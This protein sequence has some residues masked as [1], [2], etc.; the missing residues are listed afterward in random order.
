M[1]LILNFLIIKGNIDKKRL[2]DCD[3]MYFNALLTAKYNAFQT[4]SAFSKINKFEQFLPICGFF[5]NILQ[6]LQF[7]LKDAK[8]FFLVS[9][10]SQNFCKLR[11]LQFS[12]FTL[13]DKKYF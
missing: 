8:T 4:I 5:R 10:S 12:K 1:H 13:K 7:F 11:K 9:K 3:F 2:Y 6:K